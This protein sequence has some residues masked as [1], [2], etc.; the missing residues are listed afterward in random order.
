MW[1]LHEGGAGPIGPGNKYRALGQRGWGWGVR[2]HSRVRPYLR[3]QQDPGLY[4]RDVE[5]TGSFQAGGGDGEG[6]VIT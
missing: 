4:P 6:D 3:G 2:A 1:G 5:A